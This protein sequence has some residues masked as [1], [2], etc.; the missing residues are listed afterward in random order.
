MKYPG[1]HATMQNGYIPTGGGIFWFRHNAGSEL[2]PFAKVLPGTSSWFRW[3]KLEAYHCSKCHLVMFRYGK[4][5][6]QTG[7]FE[8]R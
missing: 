1:C 4:Q 2:L 6:E 5:V 8:H 7:G 3:A